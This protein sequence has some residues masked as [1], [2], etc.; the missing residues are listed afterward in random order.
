MANILVNS[1]RNWS[2]AAQFS[3]FFMHKSILLSFGL[4]SR[5]SRVAVSCLPLLQCQWASSGQRNHL[6]LC[7]TLKRQHTIVDMNNALG[8]VRNVS[9]SKILHR[10]EGDKEA[11]TNVS[12][13]DKIDSSSDS[14]EDYPEVS[15]VETGSTNTNKAEQLSDVDVDKEL[16]RYD[17]EEFELIPDEEVSIVQ[18]VKESIPVELKSE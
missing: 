13:S 7:S 17:Y 3:N 2:R 9:F 10:I 12:S 16:L 1:W 8:S 11:A 14:A 5:H 6:F 18:P 15:D 4:F